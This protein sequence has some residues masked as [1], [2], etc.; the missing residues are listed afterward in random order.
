[1]EVMERAFTGTTPATL[2]HAPEFLFGLVL[3][4]LVAGAV[5]I[6]LTFLERVAEH[7]AARLRLRCGR[8]PRGRHARA[9][10]PWWRG[11]APASAA[12]PRAPPHLTAA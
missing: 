12:R 3:Q 2:T 11:A 1:M 5:L 7:V 9:P 6:V 10:V 8:F 4:V